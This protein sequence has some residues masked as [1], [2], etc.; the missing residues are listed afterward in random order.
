M[1]EIA[2]DQST[3]TEVIRPLT[4]ENR[5]TLALSL[6]GIEETTDQLQRQLLDTLGRVDGF[7]QHQPACKTDDG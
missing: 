5:T 7:H 3:C 4:I 6:H 2:V 1:E